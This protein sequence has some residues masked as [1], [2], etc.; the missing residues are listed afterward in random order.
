MT[1]TQ[2][3]PVSTATPAVRPFRITVPEEAL[4]DLRRR[5]AATRWPDRETVPDQS[6]GVPLAKIQPL[7]RY[8]GTDYDWRKGEAKLNALPQFV[9]EIDG[10]DIQFAHVRSRHPDAL[11]LIMTHGWP[12]SIFELLKVIDPLTDPTAHGA[13]GRR[14]PSRAAH[15]SGLWLLGQAARHW[16]GSRPRRARLARADATPGIHAVCV[17][18]R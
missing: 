9:T 4:V 1:M 11:P 17:P 12:G 18:G 7:V 6:Q 5:V 10:L 13:R 3:D 16:L 8:W 15:V 2:R 14:L